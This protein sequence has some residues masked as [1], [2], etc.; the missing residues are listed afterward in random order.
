[1]KKITPNCIHCSCC[2]CCVQWLLFKVNLTK[3]PHFFIFFLFSPQPALIFAVYYCLYL[4]FIFFLLCFITFHLLHSFP[5]I[6]FKFFV[7]YYSLI[8]LIE[9][10]F[11]FCFVF[12]ASFIF[13]KKIDF[14][15]RFL[16]SYHSECCC[17]DCFYFISFHLKNASVSH[18]FF[19]SL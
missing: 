17:Y 2:C 7:S 19:M 3:W 13:I 8:Y 12:V 1:M 15:L 16:F 14:Y 5:F 10:I 9:F 18:T 11:I 6:A 4:F